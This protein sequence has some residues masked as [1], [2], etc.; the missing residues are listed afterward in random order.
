LVDDAKHFQTGHAARVL[1]RLP[2]AIIEVGGNGHD[3]L[4]TLL[5]QVRLGGLLQLAQDHGRD[6]RWG[7]LLAPHF[8][9]DVAVGGL[10]HFVRDELD[11]LEHLVVAASHE[12]LDREDGVLWIRDRLSLSDLSDED[13]AVLRE[14]RDRGCQSATL[15]VRDHGGIAALDDRDHRVGRPE[16]NAYHLRHVD[17]PFSLVSMATERGEPAPSR[18]L[19]TARSTYM[20]SILIAL[21]FTSSTF[22]SFTS[23]TPSRYVAFTFS[24]CTGIGSCTLRSNFPATGAAGWKLSR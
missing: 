15:L 4:S 13:L 6:L 7:V 11:L 3:A 17:S 9:P 8:D 5:A 22:G 1:G 2:L 12:P 21:G 14:S 23:R 19:R 16:V 20:M 18:Q 24:A 10:D